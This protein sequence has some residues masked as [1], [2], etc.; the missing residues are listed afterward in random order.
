MSDKI[1]WLSL[2]V[3]FLDYTIDSVPIYFTLLI[4]YIILIGLK[5][6]IDTA[7]RQYRR[8]LL[9][10]KKENRKVWI[11]VVYRILH[12]IIYLLFIIFVSGSNV[13]F[14]VASLIGHSVGIALVF[15]YQR[16]D[17]RHPLR[18]LVHALKN[19]EES[20]KETAEEVEYLVS[21]L[22]KRLVKRLKF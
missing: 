15:E 12:D 13:G 20:S 19:H 9:L 4:F 7:S 22:R 3:K 6:K 8:E 18:A 5:H 17:H 10:Q 1:S 16:Q 11:L 14:L 21:F 2:S